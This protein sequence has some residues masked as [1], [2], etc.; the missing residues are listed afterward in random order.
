M[1]HRLAAATPVK[2]RVVSQQQDTEGLESHMHPYPY[3]PP[4]L[5]P[6][7]TVAQASRWPSISSHRVSAFARCP[8]C[9]G[10]AAVSIMASY[11]IVSNHLASNDVDIRHVYRK[12][13]S[14]RRSV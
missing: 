7:L 4:S 9:E 2:D 6:L 1:L 8:W 13:S 14:Q 10:A 11:R 12:C 3:S 5:E